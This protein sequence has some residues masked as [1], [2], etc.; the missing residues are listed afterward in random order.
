MLSTI[1]ALLVGIDTYPAPVLSLRGCVNDADAMQQFLE[2]RLPAQH[3]SI[4]RLTNTAATRHAIIHTFREHLGQAQTGDVALFYYSGHGSQERTPLLYQT[5]EP[6]G[7]DETLVAYDSRLPGNWD[8]ADKELAVLISE[9]AAHGGHV[10]VILDSCHSGTA[11]RLAD[12][13]SVR[14]MSS[15]GRQRPVESFWFFDQGFTPSTLPQRTSG[16][17]ILPTGPHMLLSACRDFEL[18]TEFTTPDGVR[19]GL[20]SYYLLETLQQLGNA[21]RYR[22][23]HKHVQTLVSN[24]NPAQLPQAEGDLERLLFENTLIARPPHYYVRH[25]I[26]AG[27]QLDAGIVHGIQPESELAVLP[28][29]IQDYHDLSARV[30]TVRVRNVNVAASGVEVIAGQLPTDIVTLPAVVSDQPLPLLQVALDES[31]HSLPDVHNAIKNSP[32][33]ALVSTPEAADVLVLIEPQQYRLRRPLVPGDLYTSRPLHTDDAPLEIVRTLEHVARWHATTRLVNP[34]SH[35]ADHIEMLVVPWL[36]APATPG[37]DPVVDA[38][39]IGQEL[40]LPY[41][42]VTGQL[43]PGR[44]TVKLHNKGHQPL[45]F[46]LLALSENFAIQLVRGGYGRLAP[47]HTIWLRSQDGISASVPAALYAQGVTQRRD[48]LLLLVSEQDVDFSLLEQP[49]IERFSLPRQVRATRTGSVLEKLMHRIGT[50][51]LREVDDEPAQVA[52]QWAVL[53]QTVV[54]E[55]PREIHRLDGNVRT[56]QLTEQVYLHA[57]TGLHAD[58][59]LASVPEAGRSLHSALLPPGLSNFGPALQPVALAGQVGSDRGL[60]VLEVAGSDFAGITRANP[61]RVT[62]A[63]PVASDEALLAIAYDGEDYLLVGSS[64]PANPAEVVITTLPQPL[65]LTEVGE[66]DRG[67]ARTTWILFQKLAYT[68]LGRA[69]DYRYPLLRRA[70]LNEAGNLEYHQVTSVQIEYAHTIALILHGINSDTSS[71]TQ[72]MLRAKLL[73]PYDLVLTFDYESFNTRVPETAR[74]LKE[75]LEEAGF[76][77]GHGKRLDCIAHCM[78]GVVARWLIEREQ[79]AGFMQNLVLIGTPN[80]G[81]P[82]SK[83]Q[84]WLFLGIGFALNRFISLP[85][86]LAL[87]AL[88]WGF[89]Y[90]DVAL[91]D[92]APR[93]AMLSDLNSSAA[94]PVPYTT[95]TGNVATREPSQRLAGKILRQSIDLLFSGEIHDLLVGYTSMA[96]VRSGKGAQPHVITVPCTHFDYF[97]TEAGQAALRQVVEGST[98]HTP[99]KDEP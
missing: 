48:I 25:S 49:G 30:A 66:V 78:G 77:N 46:A 56:Y 23:L 19:R 85:P 6:D 9:V 94:T 1:Y 12:N 67:L 89:E 26:G 97:D 53:K 22:D 99:A 59:R 93:S 71:M 41:R 36:G 4:Q 51:P 18:A 3:R 16:W 61:L 75:R 33:L 47:D 62:S 42:M 40:R 29:D 86:V 63:L 27:W 32:Y 54:A 95:I 98:N 44:F 8:I 52:H 43:Q 55:H 35:L 90:L 74:K 5:V 70:V 10:L 34:E 81:T 91:D 57:P 84:D 80:E 58:V 50:L 92:L 28:G 88:L 69:E 65:A 87:R 13:I 83:V 17:R 39:E 7:R 82:L 64:R 15:D 31:A 37:A 76:R 96:Q 2:H 14:R 73:D 60:S 45:F 68:H 21:I 20:F 11:T 38:V 24:Q 72:T 79:G